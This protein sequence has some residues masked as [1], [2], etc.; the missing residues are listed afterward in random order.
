MQDLLRIW[1]SVQALKGFKQEVTWTFQFNKMI[2]AQVENDLGQ[3]SCEENQLGSF[4]LVQVW[5][6]GSPNLGVGSEDFEKE[7][8][9][10]GKTDKFENWLTMEVRGRK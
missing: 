8:D 9:F 7:T 2:L 5:D 6:N 4:C 1:V 3:S 10:G